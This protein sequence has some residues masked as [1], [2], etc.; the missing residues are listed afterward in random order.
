MAVGRGG[1]DRN[2]CKGRRR[3]SPWVDM[4]RVAIANTKARASE[5][6]ADDDEEGSTPV[7]HRARPELGEQVSK[8][9]IYGRRSRARLKAMAGG[10]ACVDRPDIWRR[11][12][13][14]ALCASHREWGEGA[15]I[16]PSV[17]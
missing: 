17:A 13:N 5:K 16:T 8:A 2:E 9:T 1:A 7:R 12:P 11:Q 14:C 4:A 3:V 6:T 10:V 15:A